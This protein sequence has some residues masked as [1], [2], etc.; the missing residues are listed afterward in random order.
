MGSKSTNIIMRN[1]KEEILLHLRDNKPAILY[2][3][4][5]V[6][7]G[8]Y[9]EEGETPEQCIIREMMEELG[10]ELTGVSL[11]LAAQRSYGFEYTFWARA[12]FRV[13]AIKLTEGQAIRWFT[14]DEIEHTELG[15]EDNT[16]LKEFFKQKPVVSKRFS[17][18]HPHL[19]SE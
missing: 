16:I 9:I 10:V 2:P 12:N 17:E 5:W 8:G 19:K 6:L 11:F 3:N 13:E 15:Y 14:R 4:R 18:A 1:D 7:P